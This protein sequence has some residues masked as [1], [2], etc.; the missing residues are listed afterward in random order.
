MPTLKKPI[1]QLSNRLT[2]RCCHLWHSGIAG[3]AKDVTSCICSI[4]HTKAALIIAKCAVRSIT[5]TGAR[6]NKNSKRAVGAKN[7]EFAKYIQ[8]KTENP[9]DYDSYRESGTQRGD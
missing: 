7:E 8:E 1:C 4:Q 2:W 3:D 9:C 6:M 5:A